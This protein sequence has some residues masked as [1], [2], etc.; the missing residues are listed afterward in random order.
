MHHFDPDPDTGASDIFSP[1][2]APIYLPARIT[3]GNWPPVELFCAVYGQ[4]AIARWMLDTF[5]SKVRKAYKD[6]FYPGGA[7]NSREGGSQQLTEQQKRRR[8]ETNS[9]SRARDTRATKRQKRYTDDGND[10]EQEGDSG[11]RN[12]VGNDVFGLLVQLYQLSGG[13]SR[14]QWEDAGVKIDGWL[15]GVAAGA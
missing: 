13:L 15:Q 6:R 8:E 10:D 1:H 12:N 7:R 5:S 11:D 4:A 14:P 9:Q 2:A 3:K